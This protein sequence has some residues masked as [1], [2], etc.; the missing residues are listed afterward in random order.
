M[1]MRGAWAAVGLVLAGAGG[2]LAAPPVIPDVP[3]RE[4]E[5]TA[6]IGD[7]SAPDRGLV[8]LSDG[9][10]AATLLVREAG[11][12]RSQRSSDGG[13]TWLAEIDRSTTACPSSEAL[14]SPCRVRAPL[15]ISTSLRTISSMETISTG[16]PLASLAAGSFGAGAVLPNT[17]SGSST[18]AL[19][20][21]SAPCSIRRESSARKL[22]A[23]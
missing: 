16:A 1:R 4:V 20:S 17:G 15:T 2:A 11:H 22:V 10:G 3:S 9:S 12:L 21:L 18:R 23:T 19:D 5:V 14:M 13:A 8:T 6:A 7:V